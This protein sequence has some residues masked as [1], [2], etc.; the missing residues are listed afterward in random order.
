MNS[1]IALAGLGKALASVLAKRLVDALA[2]RV[3]ARHTNTEHTITPRLEN[4]LN[5]ILGWSER[6][7]FYG[8]SQALDTDTVS[9]ELGISATPRRFSAGRQAADWDEDKVLSAPSHLLLLGDPGAGKSTTLKRLCR[10]LLLEGSKHVGDQLQFPILLRL[11]H[12]PLNES[13]Y[14]WL[15]SAMGIA[16]KPEVREGYDSSR[17]QHRSYLPD[18]GP[19]ESNSTGRLLVGDRELSEVMVELIDEARPLICVERDG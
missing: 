10:R 18:P 1:T 6:I 3:K 5:G 9:V 12:M 17:A 16:W 15:A 8:L 2:D 11:R 7:P 13:L 19:S 14:Q 4:H